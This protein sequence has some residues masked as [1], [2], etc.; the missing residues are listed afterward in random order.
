MMDFSVIKNVTNSL[1][2]EVLIRMA[3]LHIDRPLWQCEV[4]K[5]KGRVHEVT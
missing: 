1:R 3:S 2:V 5:L 4:L